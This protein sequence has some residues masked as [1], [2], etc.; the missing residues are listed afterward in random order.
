MITPC[1]ERVPPHSQLGIRIDPKRAF[2]PKLNMLNWSGHI[3]V[4]CND[5]KKV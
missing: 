3:I 4:V 2:L 5:D 1:K